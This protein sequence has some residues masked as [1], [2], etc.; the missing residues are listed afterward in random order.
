MFLGEHDLQTTSGHEQKIPIA[1]IIFHPS[2]NPSNYD[3]DL[4]LVKLSRKAT[5]ND[6][7]KTACLPDQ[8]TDFSN[9]T[10]CYISGWGLLQAYGKGP[11]VGQLVSVSFNNEFF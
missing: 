6:R 2:Y 9:G 7:V 4:A 10:K 11:K 3:Y 8:N 1:D 5:I